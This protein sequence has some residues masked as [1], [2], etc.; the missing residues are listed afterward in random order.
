VTGTNRL[1][2]RKPSITWGS[3][4]NARPAF[5]FVLGFRVADR[6]PLKIRDRIGA[7]TF[8]WDVPAAPHQPR[9]FAVSSALRV[10]WLIGP[11]EGRTH[12]RIAIISDHPP[13]DLSRLRRGQP[14]RNFAVLKSLTRRDPR[15]R[16]CLLGGTMSS[17]WI[18]IKRRLS[19]RGLA[20]EE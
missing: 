10:R 9:Q 17:I 1:H 6:L 7:T 2:G 3:L 8:E 11:P 5:P 15:R 13:L 20:A 19:L 14:H 4:S 16:R 18:S 12:C